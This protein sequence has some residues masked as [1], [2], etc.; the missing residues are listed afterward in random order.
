VD[1]YPISVLNI[2]LRGGFLFLAL[3]GRPAPLTID[4]LPMI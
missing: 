2:R 1:A 3:T 4:R